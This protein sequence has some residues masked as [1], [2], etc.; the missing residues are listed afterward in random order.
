MRR[1]LILRDFFT[2]M[3]KQNINYVVLRGHSHIFD[4]PEKDV[5]L[6]VDPRDFNRIA[7]L[8]NH[9][10]KKFDAIAIS[11]M[12]S[13]KN[14]YMKSIAVGND[15][16]SIEGIYIHCVAF[17]TL[18]TGFL[19]RRMR[20]IGHHVWLHDLASIETTTVGK[21]E[22]K[23]PPAKFIVL[24]SLAKLSQSPNSRRAADLNKIIE[25]HSLKEWMM[26]LDPD[27]VVT[28]AVDSSKKESRMDGIANVVA[29]CS[30]NLLS[31]HRQHRITEYSILIWHNLLSLLQL[32]GKLIFFSGPDGSGK[33]TAN[34]ALSNVLRNKLKVS[35]I[36]RK[37]LYPF[38]QRLQQRIQPLQAHIRHIDLTD[39]MALERDRGNSI[40]WKLR[41]LAGLIFLLAQVW[42]GYLYARWQNI[43]GYTVIID[44][45][46][47]DM[48]IKGHRP[49]FPILRKISLPL[50]PSGDF[51][52]M[53]TAEPSAIVARKPELTEDEIIEYYNFFANMKRR[54]N[55]QAIKIDSTH[56][57]SSALSDILRAI[58]T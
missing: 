2:Q 31:K 13:G 8:F 35:V 37:A 18:K 7:D 14:L 58:G 40:G 4:A 50:L 29:T 47:F 52:F 10:T 3:L 39:S 44:T 33:T 21:I 20:W 9:L 24:F 6:L 36:N 46:F 17:V 32:K 26:T 43:K 15:K 25:N 55:R 49:P 51:W 12:V 1:T 27:E 28:R 38:S 57:V 48:F 45:A 19:A 5:D 56:G 41:R 42:P 34:M 54:E 23:I 11:N 30:L 16:E 53:M 22:I